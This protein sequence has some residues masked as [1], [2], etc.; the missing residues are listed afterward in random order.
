MCVSFYRLSN[1]SSASARLC[2]PAARI[3]GGISLCLPAYRGNIKPNGYRYGEYRFALDQDHI[4]QLL[5]GESLYSTSFVFIREILQNAIDATRV[6]L[7]L[8]RGRGN[9]R[10]EP[11]AIRVSEWVDADRYR[12]VRVDDFGIGMD[13]EII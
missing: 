13:E 3:D 4:L 6:R 12:W 7:F 8:E 5:T 9:S 10:F 1:A 2:C 11:Q